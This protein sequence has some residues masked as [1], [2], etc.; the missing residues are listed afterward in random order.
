MSSYVPS[1]APILLP[2]HAA[3]KRFAQHHVR[4]RPGTLEPAA[5]LAAGAHGKPP[6]VGRLIVPDVTPSLPA[7]YRRSTRSSSSWSRYTRVKPRK[8]PSDSVEQPVE[9]RRARWGRMSTASRISNAPSGV[10]VGCGEGVGERVGDGTD[11]GVASGVAVAVDAGDGAEVGAAGVVAGTG[12]EVPGGGLSVGAGPAVVPA[13]G[14]ATRCSAAPSSA[15]CAGGKCHDQPKRG[16]Q[17]A[18]PLAG[19]HHNDHQSAH[20]QHAIGMHPMHDAWCGAEGAATDRDPA[21]RRRAQALCRQSLSDE[22]HS[23]EERHP[24][25]SRCP[26]ERLEVP[27]DDLVVRRPYRVASCGTFKRK[28]GATKQRTLR[29]SV[30]SCPCERAP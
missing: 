21:R 25:L 23:R 20:R 28:P 14:E 24:R 7:A 12:L 9:T 4:R 26:V 27:D 16:R 3:I 10:L 17:Q 29:R 2:R 8:P 19:L 11:G 18:G 5:V 6:T 22:L 30:A 15:D 1:V 13:L